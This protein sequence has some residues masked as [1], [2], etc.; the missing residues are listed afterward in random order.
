MKHKLQ[1]RILASLALIFT[2]IVILWIFASI[3][4]FFRTGAEK[5]AFEPVPDT[6]YE[7]HT[8]F[9]SLQTSPRFTGGLNSDK[10]MEQVTDAYLKSWRSYNHSLEHN[11][12]HLL[13]DHF[14]ESLFQDV[15]KNIEN[16]K[17]SG[18]HVI[19]IDAAHNLNFHLVST[20]QQFVAFTDKQVPVYKHVYKDNQL[21]LDISTIVDIDVLM[22]LEEGFWKVFKWVQTVSEV[23]PEE[24]VADDIN[25]F[26]VKGND[27]L[28]D[29]QPFESKGVNYYPAENPW[30]EMWLNFDKE[31]IDKD[32]KRIQSFGLNTIRVF[33]PYPVFGGSNVEP[34][35][36]L[37][38]D[39][40]MQ[41]A[42]KYDLYLIPT[43]FDFNPDYSHL[44]YT[45]A[46]KHLRSIVKRYTDNKAIL[47]WDIKNEP[48]LDFDHHSKTKVLQ[49]LS[50]IV[51]RIKFY[52]PN[53]L[54]TIGWSNADYADLLEDKVD[55]VSFH[56][57]KPDDQL[58][59][60]IR[61]LKNKVGN[62]VLYL[63][64]FGLSTFNWFPGTQGKAERKQ[65]ALLEYVIESCAEENIGYAFWTLN[66]FHQAPKYVFGKLPWRRWPQ[67]QFGIINKKGKEKRAAQIFENNRSPS[68][69]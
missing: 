47:A 44:S 48:D 58:K 4:V 15:R 34:Q 51:D 17:T 43:L 57:Y 21:V 42:N 18:S 60:D 22:L 66:D 12:F 5:Y 13:E 65:T 20:D 53:H 52:D 38:L 59:N 54:V 41:L 67:T 10:I 64:E 27:L 49:W 62:R 31:T 19:Q 24:T 45:N 68:K 6:F 25:N 1:H 8:P 16:N 11:S 7:N 61:M 2:L 3:I 36:L 35:R 32:F 9:V 63:Q 50:Y 69:N 30:F 29:N 55:I 28:K 26:S 40:V 56:F 33:I 46:D 23:E 39:T 14:S 37:Q